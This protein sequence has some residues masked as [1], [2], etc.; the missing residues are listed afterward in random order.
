MW[1]PSWAIEQKER[2]L[3]LIIKAYYNYRY[4]DP[5]I[6]KFYARWMIDV[7]GG[8]GDYSFHKRFA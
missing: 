4:T 8:G 7:D 3:M 2:R 6:I 5:E 1:L